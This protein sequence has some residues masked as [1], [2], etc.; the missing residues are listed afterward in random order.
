[1]S[2]RH[3]VRKLAG[4]ELFQIRY[5]LWRFIPSLQMTFDEGDVSVR[6]LRMGEESLFNFLGTDEVTI[7]LKLSVATTA[8]NILTMGEALYEVASA[9]VAS[10]SFGEKSCGG[11]FRLIEVTDSQSKSGDV[12]FSL[13]F[14][15]F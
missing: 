7:F 2:G 9:V 3:P 5:F 10:A 1:M 11:E 8:K 14:L 13:I 15:M 12:K 6:N 4:E